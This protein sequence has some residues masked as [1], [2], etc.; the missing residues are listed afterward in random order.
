[1]LDSGD[2]KF[3]YFKDTVD[4]DAEVWKSG[5]TKRRSQENDIRV[6]HS[7]Q[8]TAPRAVKSELMEMEERGEI[9]LFGGGYLGGC[10]EWL[11]VPLMRGDKVIGAL[12]VQNYT[13]TYRY[14]EKEKDLLVFVSQHIAT[15]LMRKR[16]EQ[17]LLDAKNDLEERVQERTKEL[18][19]SNLMLESQIEKI[20]HAEKLQGAMYS[21]A[22]ASNQTLDLDKF[23]QSIHHSISDLVYAENLFIA[24]IDDDK[25]LV[26]FVYVQDEFRV[27]FYES[28]PLSNLL[29]DE[30]TSIS[31]TGKV[32]KTKKPLL[33]SQHN[34]Q[35][36]RLW[37]RTQSKG[38]V[39]CALLS[40]TMKLRG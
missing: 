9:V 19:H 30:S 26:N 28:E 24:L 7:A 21:I 18:R 39:G 22:E 14:T 23:Y 2:V 37:P 15:T 31:F 5:I 17:A 20:A 38:L 8:K 12:V 32:I 4:E 6:G 25:K 34:M 33:L 29:G 35:T 27:D 11:G 13:D 16:A 40:I 1:M 36:G 3:L 10:L